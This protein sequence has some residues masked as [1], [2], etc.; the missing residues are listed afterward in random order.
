LL[1][2]SFL[3]AA[4]AAILCSPA[5]S[6]TSLKF[7]AHKLPSGLGA[8][9]SVDGLRVITVRKASEGPMSVASQVAQRLGAA[10]EEGATADQVRV[11][12]GGA[13]FTLWVGQRPIITITK[14]FAYSN[15]STPSGLASNWKA[16]LRRVFS[17][18]Y[19]SMARSD[20]TI[21][22]G[23]QRS[24]PLAGNLKQGV[25]AEGAA[26]IVEWK[27]Q[28]GNELLL[29]GKKP[30]RGVLFVM[31]GKARLPLEIWVAR[32]AGR[33]EPFAAAIVT[34]VSVPR[35]IMQKAALLAARQGVQ[36]EEGAR[37]R[38]LPPVVSA[39]SLPYGQSTTAT[40]GVG[41]YGDD[42]LPAQGDVSVKVVNQGVER[43]DARELLVS[44][45]PEK[46]GALGLWYHA[47]IERDKPARFLYHHVNDTG[48]PADLV[49][50]LENSSAAQ[51]RVQIIEGTGG[52]GRDEIFVGHVAAR[53]F[54]ERQAQDV[55]YVVTLPAGQR[56]AAALHEMHQGQV[57]SGLMEFRLLDD[58]KLAVNL[59]I[60]EHGAGF[61]LAPDLGSAPVAKAVTFVFPNP[62]KTLE[63]SYKVG[64]NWAF[65]RL[66]DDPLSD[67]SKTL[68]GNYGVI[69]QVRITM[70]NPTRAAADVE[71]ALSA[72]AGLARGVFLVDGGEVEAPL[73]RAYQEARIARFVLNPGATRV[74]KVRTLPQSGSNYP[75]RLMVR[76]YGAKSH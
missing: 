11:T 48:G 3:A 44:N 54:L 73:L 6:V 71:I 55:G 42:Y 38:M 70:E 51:A 9:V 25:R 15:G 74:V 49:V 35:A 76:P 33:I 68:A 31:T 20:Q 34:G 14:R 1:Y 72:S 50:E 66:G 40:V 26:D 75:V 53:D 7:T 52:P 10:V 62:Q 65:M 64:G 32:Y 36:P 30:G 58:A 29:T 39:G 17:I 19:V 13:M 22:V 37:I 16:S 8:G 12:G 59:R 24:V 18:P 4:F 21:P 46:L 69:Y 27:V 63:A 60:V 23:E 57:V 61:L 41:V 28:P 56:Y 2:R 43:K 47:P 45:N 5:A 67:G